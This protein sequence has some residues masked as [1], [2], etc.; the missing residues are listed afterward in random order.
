M[1]YCPG[2]PYPY[3]C[4]CPYPYPYPYPYPL[5]S[6]NPKP[7]PKPA[8]TPTP[9]SAVPQENSLLEL[10]RELLPLPDLEIAYCPGDIFAVVADALAAR[11]R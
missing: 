11:D 8:P 4:P 10:I 6:P 5:P 3:P 1:T 7:N 2:E 9:P